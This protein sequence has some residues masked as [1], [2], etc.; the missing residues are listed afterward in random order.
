MLFDVARAAV[1]DPHQGLFVEAV[2]LVLQRLNVGDIVA[3][4]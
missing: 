1:E 2:D 3:L 4:W